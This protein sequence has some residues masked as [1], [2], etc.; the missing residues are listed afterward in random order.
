MNEVREIIERAIEKAMPGGVTGPELKKG[1]AKT[2]SPAAAQVAVSKATREL[3]AQGKVRRETEPGG[4][5]RWFSTRAAAAPVQTSA[6]EPPAPPRARFQPPE[7]PP[8]PRV[9][10]LEIPAGVLP[11]PAHRLLEK[12]RGT[13]LYGTTDGE[14]IAKLVCER[15]HELLID[16]TLI[17]SGD[18]RS[19]RDWE[20]DAQS[21]RE[22]PRAAIAAS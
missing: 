9:V 6:P 20:A 11:E 17:D 14:T 7:L 5:F 4:A 22:R 12:L 1:L 3:L 21:T 16:G 13:G 15:L 8:L 2:H 18:W 19:E 10:G